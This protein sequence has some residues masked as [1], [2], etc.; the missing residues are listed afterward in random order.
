MRELRGR[1][2]GLGLGDY[3]GGRF[4]DRVCPRRPRSAGDDQVV[5]LTDSLGKSHSV[6]G[7]LL[8]S[9]WIQPTRWPPVT[10]FLSNDCG[11]RLWHF[12]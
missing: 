9:R 7:A 10:S 2:R 11:K 5:S 12:N 8:E 1:V 3:Y 4:E 6:L